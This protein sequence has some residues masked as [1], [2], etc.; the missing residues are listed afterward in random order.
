MQSSWL[1][2]IGQRTQL[3]YFLTT[4]VLPGGH[5]VTAFPLATRPTRSKLHQDMYIVPGGLPIRA[6]AG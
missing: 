2:K 6:Q 5:A 3:S 4:T 1:A